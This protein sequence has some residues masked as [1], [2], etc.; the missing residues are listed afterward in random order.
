LPQVQP[1]DDGVKKV[2]DVEAQLKLQQRLLNDIK[3]RISRGEQIPSLVQ[4]FKNEYRNALRKWNERTEDVRYLNNENYLDFKAKVW[5]VNHPND[6]MPPLVDDGEQDE[7][8]MVMSTSTV[9][10]KCPITTTYLEDP[11]TSQVCKHSFSKEAIVT[12]IRRT[13]TTAAAC[14]VSGCNKFIKISDLKPN[15]SLARRVK[16]H[17]QS[18]GEEEEEE[19]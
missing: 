4:H 19:E 3:M 17:L 11:V 9:T 1:L 2:I 10:L 12:H 7:D 14:P 6:P 8:I 16:Q 5:E 13:Q 18:Q 15:K